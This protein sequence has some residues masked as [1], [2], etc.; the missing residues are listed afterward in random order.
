MSLYGLLGKT[1]K[2][3]FS[4]TFF[5]EKFAREGLAGHRYEN[6]ELEHIGQLTGLLQQH[7][8]IAGLNVTIPYKEEVL[9]FLHYKN[10]VV[11]AIGACN[12]IK[13]SEGQLYGFNTDVVGFRNSLQP[14][15]GPQHTNAL[16]LG[17]GGAAKAVLY[18]LQQLGIAATVVSRTRSAATIGYD[19]V[20]EAMM[21]QHLLVINTS[22]VG[23]YPHVDAAPL[24][25]YKAITPQHL[26]FDLIY[27]PEQTLF[28]QKGA[29]KGAATV[30]GYEMLVGQALE[31]W[32]IWNEAVPNGSMQKA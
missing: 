31:S 23:M 18:V 29:A 32:R 8:D 5:T 30:N 24:L 2:H 27:N 25:P 15:L 4:K 20:D 16:V 9:S 11:A 7:P 21:Q 19:D 28:L 17:T 13:I 22:P 26:L 10:D 3:S 14:H 12:C 1:L 6:F